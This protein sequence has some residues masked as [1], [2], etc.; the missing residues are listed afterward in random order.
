[1]RK[2]CQFVVCVL[3][4]ELLC[5]GLS[6]YQWGFYA[7]RRINEMAVFTMPPALIGF[8]KRHLNYLSRHASDPDK[9]RF[10]DPSEPCRHFF[11]SEYYGAPVFDSIPRKWQEAVCK[12][13]KDSMKRHGILPWYIER[14][15]HRLTLAFQEGNTERILHY[16][17]DLGHY[18]GDAHVP[19]HA[20]RNYNGQFTEQLGIHAFW[21]SR[22][23][24]LKG[25]AYDYFAGR[26]VY[27]EHPER[28]VWIV[29]QE[30][31]LEVDSVLAIEKSLNDRFR[32]DLK[33][34]YESRGG[35]LQKTYSFAYTEAYNDALGHMPEKKLLQSIQL[36]GSLWYTAWVN[37]GQPEMNQ[38]GGE[39]SADSLT[40]A[41]RMDENKVSD[42]LLPALPGH[43]E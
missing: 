39:M 15:V 8:Y 37:A 26:A 29:L 11:D 2:V 40:N 4:A 42:H 32:A 17:S 18:V 43:S 9:R 7:H 34:S 38:L 33:F 14:L 19:L 36:L 25:E 3:M 16:S 23:P 6:C 31:Y 28:E 22:I 12:Y 24:E 1:M 20:T 30:S 27:L 35:V 13:G 5:S 41:G 21:E 10:A